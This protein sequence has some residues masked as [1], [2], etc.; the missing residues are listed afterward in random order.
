[1]NNT[2]TIWMEMYKQ[3]N[4]RKIRTRLLEPQILWVNASQR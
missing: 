3:Q 2:E 1:M 4:K